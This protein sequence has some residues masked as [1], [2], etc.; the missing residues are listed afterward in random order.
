MTV[1]IVDQESRNGNLRI[2]EAYYIQKLKPQ[3]NSKEEGCVDL[4][5]IHI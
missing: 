4:S 3:I 1:S 2:R 5:L